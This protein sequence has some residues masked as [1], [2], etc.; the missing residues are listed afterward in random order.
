MQL[1]PI[2]FINETYNDFELRTGNYRKKFS[3]IDFLC[4]HLTIAYFLSILRL[5]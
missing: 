2:K 4:V 5:Y 3:I 1:S